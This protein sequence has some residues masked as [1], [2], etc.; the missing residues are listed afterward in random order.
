MQ[1]EQEQDIG[2]M[3]FTVYAALLAEPFVKVFCFCMHP[4]LKKPL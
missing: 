2:E 3:S 1:I 4:F